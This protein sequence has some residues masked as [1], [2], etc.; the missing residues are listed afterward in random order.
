MY[1][2]GLIHFTKYWKLLSYL[3]VIWVILL[4]VVAKFPTHFSDLHV[5]FVRE[6]IWIWMNNSLISNDLIVYY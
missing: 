2:L 5:N 1:E 6:N 3:Y 4:F